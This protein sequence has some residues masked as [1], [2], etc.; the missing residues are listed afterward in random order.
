MTLHH[1]REIG[2]SYRP[3]PQGHRSPVDTL[4]IADLDPEEGKF[5]GENETVFH[6]GFDRKMLD[7]ILTEAGFNVV[8]EKTAAIMEKTVPGWRRRDLQYISHNLS[9]EGDGFAAGN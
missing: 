6:E 2:T 5:H 8:R 1:V 3:V 4:C 9:K 7:N